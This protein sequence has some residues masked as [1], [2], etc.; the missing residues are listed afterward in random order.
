M[1]HVPS[2]SQMARRARGTVRHGVWRRGGGKQKGQDERM[3]TLSLADFAARV[4]TRNNCLRNLT[5][6][7]LFHFYV[8]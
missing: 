1:G 7:T 2:R 5:E 8:L 3:G 4:P 6:L